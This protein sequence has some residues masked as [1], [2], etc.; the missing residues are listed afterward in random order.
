M[1]DKD[2]RAR[3]KMILECHEP[4]RD[5]LEYLLFIIENSEVEE[6]I[7]RVGFVFIDV[8]LQKENARAILAKS[9][10]ATLGPKP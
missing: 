1:S 5:A 9:A 3:E 8:E 10:P 4:M 6:Y 2:R 7:P